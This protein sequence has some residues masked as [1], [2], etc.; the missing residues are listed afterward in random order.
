MTKI[1]LYRYTRPDGGVTVSPN[2]PD[3]M[4]TTMLRLI[5]DEGKDLTAGVNRTK[6]VDVQDDIGWTEIDAE[7]MEE[8][9]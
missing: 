8:H 5:A 3:C 6:C 9:L 1:T 2:K 4:Y 7:E